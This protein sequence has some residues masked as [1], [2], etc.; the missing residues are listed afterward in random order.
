[1]TINQAIL[2][3]QANFL[4]KK[5]SHNED[6]IYGQNEEGTQSIL[7]DSRNLKKGYP[8]LR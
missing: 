1:M 4:R 2:F 7:A 5:G 6:E 8:Q 3:P